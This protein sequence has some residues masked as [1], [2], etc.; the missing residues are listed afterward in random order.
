VKQEVANLPSPGS[1]IKIFPKECLWQKQCSEKPGN[2][3]SKGIPSEEM[4][5]I[6]AALQ[7]TSKGVPQ[8]IG[9]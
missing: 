4:D 5:S 3:F 7:S 8:K 1:G 9:L 6:L 2:I